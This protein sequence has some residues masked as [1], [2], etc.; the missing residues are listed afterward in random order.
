MSTQ[1]KSQNEVQTLNQSA[2]EMNKLRGRSLEMNAEKRS[3]SI[4]FQMR[5]LTLHFPPPIIEFD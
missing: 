4:E 5:K 1:F 3:E 2:P